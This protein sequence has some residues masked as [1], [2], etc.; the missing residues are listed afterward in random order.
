MY[1]SI[2]N[3]NTQGETYLLG[4]PKVYS[5]KELMEL[6]LYVTERKRILIPIPTAI[7]SFQAL[8]L[9]MLPKP[10]LT[11]D[12]VALMEADNIV[13]DGGQ[14]FEALEIR[15]TPVEAI[16]PTYLDRFRRTGRT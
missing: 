6:V 15:P 10:M 16:L 11:P 14:G 12:Q 4:G 5:F 1:E 3:R 2:G 8:F 13:P 9:Q 7:A